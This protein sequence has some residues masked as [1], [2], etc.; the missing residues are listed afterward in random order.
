VPSAPSPN[1]PQTDGGGTELNA[2][3]TTRERLLSADVRPSRQRD[4][5]APTA[6]GARETA[7]S[8][9]LVLGGSLTHSPGGVL[10]TLQTHGVHPS[11]QAVQEVW[12]NITRRRYRQAWEGAPL[13]PVGHTLE[14]RP[15]KLACG[16]CGNPLGTY[17]AYRVVHPDPTLRGEHGV[18]EKISRRY[19]RST[20]TARGQAGSRGPKSNPRF[21][22][23]GE[24]GRRAAK[25]TAC[26]RCPA[27]GQEYRHNLARLGETLFTS[28]PNATF[29]LG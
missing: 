12:S 15:R 4:D 16:R 22:L 18:V 10:Q 21:W 11:P 20:G 19:E 26:F 5:P 25:T 29:T 13:E 24:I 14:W 27:C 28:N 3:A 8:M 2:H 9:S 23:E 6:R 7:G 1:P 17:V